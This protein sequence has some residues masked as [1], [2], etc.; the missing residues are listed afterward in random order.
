MQNKIKNP[1]KV[2]DS[3]DDT[4][5]NN[6]IS[7]TEDRKNFGPIKTNLVFQE[8]SSIKGNVAKKQLN[9]GLVYSNSRF[10]KN[11]CKRKN[12]AINIKNILI[13]NPLIKISQYKFQTPNN[14][15]DSL[16]K[17]VMWNKQML[18]NKSEP[19][20]DKCLMTLYPNSGLKSVHYDKTLILSTEL[21]KIF[22][23]AQIQLIKC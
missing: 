10:G 9:R 22:S 6:V 20:H 17:S 16:N 5:P 21:G 15:K 2:D 23:K 11:I 18:N 12:K 13:H 1:F 7:G 14:G 4:Y 3:T 19:F 8:G